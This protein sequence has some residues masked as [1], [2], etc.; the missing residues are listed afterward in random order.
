MRLQSDGS[1]DTTF[2]NLSLVGDIVHTIVLDNTDAV[3]FG[4]EFTEVAS[5]GRNNIAR[6]DSAGNVD[7]SFNP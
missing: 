1:L 3:I 4:G 6:V 7:M 2:A 5:E